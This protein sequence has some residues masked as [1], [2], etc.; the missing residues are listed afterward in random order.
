MG[1]VRGRLGRVR[2]AAVRR[3]A[4]PLRAR[5]MRGVFLP[6]RGRRS[7]TVLYAAVLD[8]QTMNLHAELPAPVGAADDAELLL[9]RGRSPHRSPARVHTDRSGR[10]LVDAAVLLGA[11]TGGV[12]VRTGVTR[13]RLRVR[14]GRRTRNYPLLLVD[15]PH[16]YRGTTRPMKASPIS[17]DRYRVGRSLTGSAR[18]RHAPPRPGAEVV[19]VHIE[20]ARI[21]VRLRL[22]GLPAEDPWCEFVASGR[23]VPR[24]LTETEPGVWQTEVPLAE[25]YPLSGRREHWDVLLRSGERRPY[26]VARLL[27]DLSDPQRV[28]AMRTVL[29]APRKDALM[30][31]E[32]RYTPAGNLRFT[33]RRVEETA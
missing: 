31:V 23:R 18:L 27:H 17:G 26:R 33:C 3:I 12:P 15:A 6:L 10:V 13:L 1:S 28:L 2:R 30:S 4:A 24:P 8:G 21:D 25:M 5:L 7:A 16:T 32:P 29:V 11:E 22:V 19:D 9:G 14:T 20:H